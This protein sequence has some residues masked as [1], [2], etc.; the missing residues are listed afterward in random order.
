MTDGAA[1]WRFWID[2]GGTFTDLV[3][4]APDGRLITRKLLSEN[5]ERYQDAALEGIRDVLAQE[6]NLEP[7]RRRIGDVRM[8]T[9][10]GTNALLERKGERTALVINRGLADALRIG[11]QN[12]P[13]IFAL[14]I[15]L[16]DLVYERVIPVDGRLD[17]VGEEIEPVDADTARQSLESSYAEGIRAVAIV[18]MHAW[19]NPAHELHLGAIAARIG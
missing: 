4:R 19:R 1:G 15:R 12:R 7:A 11:Y 14:D 17:A 13:D 9:T 10:V 8:G 5:P 3:A 6:T 16:P 2:R 18:L